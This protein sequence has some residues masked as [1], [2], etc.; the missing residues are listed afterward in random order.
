MSEPEGSPESAEPQRSPATYSGAVNPAE[1]DKLNLKLWE[2]CDNKN[3]GEVDLSDTEIQSV[4]DSIFSEDFATR[5]ITIDR[6]N[7]A[8]DI[9]AK[10]LVNTLVNNTTNET[11]IFQITYALEII[12]KPAVPPLIE[13]LKQI[14]ELKNPV[15]IDLLENIVETLVRI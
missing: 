4:L 7:K 15:T 13:A 8:G 12:G 14:N 5:Q 3:I 11:L 6:L 9:V 2:K 1:S 10:Y